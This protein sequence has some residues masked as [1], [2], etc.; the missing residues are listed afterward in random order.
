MSGQKAHKKAHK[1]VV[2][3]PYAVT[4]GPKLENIQMWTNHSQTFGLVLTL[5]IFVF[6]LAPSPRN[7]PIAQCDGFTV[8][9][10][11]TDPEGFPSR[12]PVGSKTRSALDGALVLVYSSLFVSLCAIAYGSSAKRQREHLCILLVVFSLLCHL[13]C[14]S[15]FAVIASLEECAPGAGGVAELVNVLYWTRVCICFLARE[16]QGTGE[17]P[18]KDAPTF[19]AGLLSFA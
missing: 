3:H 4:V 17:A 7:Y 8:S 1:D 18:Q 15:L 12:A 14:L 6:V 5:V 11:F 9:L 19:P 13:A 16:R 2:L 10:T